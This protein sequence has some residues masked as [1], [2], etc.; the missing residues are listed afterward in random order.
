MNT[1]TKIAWRNVWRNKLR[2]IVV[3][4]SIVLGIW[5]GLFI[6]AMT[7]GLNEQ[8]MGG[9]VN[10]YLSHVQ[11]HHPQFLEDNNKKFTLTDRKQL[12]SQLDTLSV[13]KAYSQRLVLNGMA[14]T[15]KANYGIQ[16]LGINPN[17]E[18]NLTSIS[19]K[20]VAGTYFS[21]F[22]RNPIVIGKKL[23]DKLGATVKSK[24]VLSFQDAENNT[25]SQSFRV[26]G[27]FKSASS[28]FDFAS[29]FVKYKD[30]ASLTG[31]DGKIHE[32]AIL[33]H[34]IDEAS[35]VKDKLT[36]DNKVETWAELS[37][38][39]GYA[40]ETMSSFI[41]IF[42]GI[43]LIALAFG[44]IN[45]M[46][47]AILERKHEL[48]MLIS[49]GMNKRIVF[50]MILLETLFLTLIATPIGMLL[51]YWSINYFGKKGIDLSS[52]AEGLESLGIG[53]RIY[54]ELP[55]DLYISI[56]VMTLLVALLSAIIPARRAL[57]L[58]PAE[59]VKVN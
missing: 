32:I 18:K 52:V 29:V 34:K 45:T 14:A 28:T 4:T 58:N 49:V 53:S 55:T 12:L 24:V 39:L 56:T 33:C 59:A 2:S 25:I 40:Q 7:L 35:L 41:Y 20:L 13:V 48:G 26:E 51:S 9:A 47:M 27:I 30:I 16:I 50:S 11:I 17:Q 10:S 44:I 36:T 46:L 6:M 8:R 43:I 38:E 42:M 23:A 57:K 5:S 37:P 21:K 19:Q 54:T 3:I 22:K 1:L 15:A 31:L